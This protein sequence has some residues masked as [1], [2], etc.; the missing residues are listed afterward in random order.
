M[1]PSD[2]QEG[3]WKG[4]GMRRKSCKHGVMTSISRSGQQP[5]GH[6][7]H[8]RTQLH[9]GDG[10]CTPV[11]YCIPY[12][13]RQCRAQNGNATARREGE[14][15]KKHAHRI[16]DP[17]AVICQCATLH[18]P[19]QTRQGQAGSQGSTTPGTATAGAAGCCG[20]ATRG[21]VCRGV[22][23]KVSGRCG[24]G[25]SQP[26]SLPSRARGSLFR[27]PAAQ[28]ERAPNTYI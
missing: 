14:G 3:E 19:R 7:G 15:K 27:G 20:L 12:Q 16:A 9:R 8:A 5:E 13:D 17:H 11:R 25:A 18:G 22:A 1:E 28:Y 24:W 6:D 2:G 23:F 10:M 4:D 21:S 26:G